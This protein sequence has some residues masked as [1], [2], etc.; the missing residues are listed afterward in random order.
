MRPLPIVKSPRERRL[1]KALLAG[2][3]SR[4][5]LD[6]IVGA[7][8]SPQIVSQLRK[9]GFVIPCKMVPAI[10]RDGRPCRHG[11]YS[12]T[13]EDVILATAVLAEDGDV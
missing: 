4:E 6:A 2:R 10:D 3:T 9:K 12:L 5:S 1:L 11:E 7:S 8:N 13:L